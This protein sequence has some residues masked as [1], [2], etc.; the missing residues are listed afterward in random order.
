M[1]DVRIINKAHAKTSREK[2]LVREVFR[3]TLLS[4]LQNV[5]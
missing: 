5:H 4:F 3:I 2:Q 1:I